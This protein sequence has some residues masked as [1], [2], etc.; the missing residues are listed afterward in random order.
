MT[1]DQLALPST[2]ERLP[3]AVDRWMPL[4]HALFFVT[5]AI[6]TAVSC[7]MAATTPAQALRTALLAAL[8]GGWYLLCALGFIHPQEQRLILTICYF[9]LGWALWLLL[10]GPN[11]LFLFLLC[12]LI[13]QLF[14]YAPM[15]R[16]IPGICILTVLWTGQ[17][18]LLYGGPP[19]PLLALG[20]AAGAVSVI[21]AF[22]ISALIRQSAE[23][24]RLIL[25]LERTQQDLAA[26]AQ[27]AGRLE[28]R[29]GLA[30][31]IHDTLAQGYTGILLQLQ[32]AQGAMEAQ[33]FSDLSRHLQRAC[34]TAR[35][36]LE[37]SRR[38]LWALHSPEAALEDTLELRLL[39]LA[40]RWHDADE[41]AVEVVVTGESVPVDDA[42]QDLIVQAAREALANAR[43]H[44][45]ATHI[46]LTLSYL[47]DLI[48]LGAQDDG[49][50]FD[51]TRI[52]SEAIRFSDGYGLRSLRAQASQLG[53]MMTVESDLAIGTTLALA[54][55]CGGRAAPSDA[56]SNASH[57]GAS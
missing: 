42:A 20:V 24:G 35:T 6:V 55:P 34:R 15:A 9:G 56:I 5:L 48:T 14:L 39:T 45:H 23:R 1:V 29:Q 40:Q 16:A 7:A 17:L 44:A 50:G 30:G 38:A 18:F 28:E 49:C 54:L 26:T 33:D 11:T 31:E 47:G 51:A 4:W 8:L 12:G 57:T 2:S 52:M 22:F 53:G 27:R 13:P 10:T 3:H 41:L 36:T 21:M 37:D 25:L 19:G 43:K 46:T 32:A